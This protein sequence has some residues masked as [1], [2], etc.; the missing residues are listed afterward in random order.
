MMS[1]M[2]HRIYL[3]KVAYPTRKIPYI[4]SHHSTFIKRAFFTRR[5]V[6]H[7]ESEGEEG[8]D[9]VS[10][11]EGSKMLVVRQQKLHLSNQIKS[12]F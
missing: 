10:L 2:V 5:V 8:V 12:I 11:V 1:E 3:L 7:E 4:H 9:D 6:C